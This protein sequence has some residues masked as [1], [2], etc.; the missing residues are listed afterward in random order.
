MKL[1]DDWKQAYKWASTRCMALAAAVQATWVSIPEETRQ[2]VP[3]YL[4]SG[5]TIGLLVF[6]VVGRITQ[7]SDNAAS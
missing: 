2:Q 1:I 7:K 3:G 4:V 6:G 5:V